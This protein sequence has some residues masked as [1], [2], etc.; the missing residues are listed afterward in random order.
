MNFSGGITERKN[1]TLTFCGLILGLVYVQVSNGLPVTI[2]AI[3]FFQSITLTEFQV[4]LK[5]IQRYEAHHDPITLNFMAAG[6]EYT[7]PVF[8]CV[9]V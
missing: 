4:C 8:N 7:E 2:F 3:I 1:A 6:C 5:D 9:V